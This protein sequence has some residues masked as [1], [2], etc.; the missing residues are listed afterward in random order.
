VVINGAFQTHHQAALQSDGAV[1]VA[2]SSPAAELIA[3]EEWQAIGEAPLPEVDEWPRKLWISPF[4]GLSARY[5]NT[6]DLVGNTFTIVELES[7]DDGIASNQPLIVAPNGITMTPA[8]IDR[9]VAWWASAMTGEDLGALVDDYKAAFPEKP[10]VAY[11]DNDEWPSERPAWVDSRVWPSVQVYRFPNEPLDDFK[12]RTEDVVA[13]VAAYDRP[14]W[15]TL[16]MDDFNHEGTVTQTEEAIPHYIDLARRYFV[17]GLHLFA[18]RR[19]G[20]MEEYPSLRAWGHAMQE[21]N[22]AERPNR[23]DYWTP[24][25]VDLPTTLLNKLQQET[26]LMVFDEDEKDYLVDL[27]MADDNDNVVPLPPV[28]EDELLAVVTHQRSLFDEELLTA[29]QCVSLLNEAAFQLG[30]AWG[31]LLKEHGNYGVRN[32]G[33]RCSTDFLVR[34]D[35]LGYDVLIDAGNRDFGPGPATAGIGNKDTFDFTGDDEGRFV[36]AI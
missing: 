6:S 2:V 10:I 14:I 5:G 13:R 7:I 27:I 30:A 4:F 36:E 33:T 21:A 35:G 15:L 19:P 20:G 26:S 31:L 3:Q 9:T 1:L 12:Q 16:R 28:D 11:L 22:P 17:V 29:D 34:S 8:V 18:D 25:S 24:E 32:D 23:F